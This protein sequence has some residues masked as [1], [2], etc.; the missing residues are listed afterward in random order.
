MFT[1]E[2]LD[3]LPDDKLDALHSMYK[4]FRT[5]IAS[6]P[7]RKSPN[8]Y[9]LIE[10][11]YALCSFIEANEIVINIPGLT[12]PTN[13]TTDG[14]IINNLFNAVNTL[15]T[16]E[17]DKI[18]H[19]SRV[20]DIRDKYAKKFGTVLIYKFSDEEYDRIQQLINELRGE[21]VE[22]DLFD[23]KHKRRILT[24]LEK[25]QTELHKTTSTLDLVYGAIGDFGIMLG[26]FGDNVKPL[27]DRY[28]EIVRISYGV[29]ARGEQLDLPGGSQLPLLSDSEQEDSPEN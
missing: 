21:I 16:S 15:V 13:K 5:A 22:S 3:G 27:V 1:D 4:A 11:Y 10:A 24:K 18:Y 8:Y 20:S 29:Q 23:K 17:K 2:F 28:S 6:T 25:L 19:E 14:K 7:G 12:N 9:K 26:K